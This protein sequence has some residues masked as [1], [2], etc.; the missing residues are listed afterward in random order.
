MYSVRLN[1]QRSKFILYKSNN[2]ILS[3]IRFRFFFFFF[4]RFFFV[5][6]DVD[7]KLFISSNGLCLVST[8]SL[9]KVLVVLRHGLR[10]G[11]DTFRLLG[12]H[13]GS[14]AWFIFE[15]WVRLPIS[16]LIYPARH[17][18]V[19][20]QSHWE[21]GQGLGRLQSA[22]PDENCQLWVSDNWLIHPEY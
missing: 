20:R 9:K 10:L 8:L 21:V 12:Q 11:C 7:I 5:C 14:S 1:G 2:Q 17:L 19:A 16:S 15:D 3:W 22:C 6:P 4:P 13:G 18:A